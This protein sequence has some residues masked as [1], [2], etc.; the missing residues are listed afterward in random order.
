MVAAEG[1]SFQNFAR[2][3]GGGSA[4]GAIVGAHTIHGIGIPTPPTNAPGR[5]LDR[6]PEKRHEG[7]LAGDAPGIIG[8]HA[9]ICRHRSINQV[10][11]EVGRARSGD[12]GS[13]RH[14]HPVLKPF[15]TEGGEPAVGECNGAGGTIREQLEGGR[16]VPRL[17]VEVG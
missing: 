9:K 10:K 2:R 3:I 6:I 4:P 16:F 1:E 5:P 7:D 14:W 11:S 12:T 17:N 13:V 15:I 8:D